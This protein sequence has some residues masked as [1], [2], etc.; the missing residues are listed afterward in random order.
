MTAFLILALLPALHRAGLRFSIDWADFLK[1]YWVGQAMRSAAA[2]AVLYV[3]GFPLRE[4]LIPLWNR[5]WRHKGRFLVV[6]VFIVYILWLFGWWIGLVLIVDTIAFL[7]LFD[8]IA[9]DP[10]KLG[11]IA[12]KIALPAA[13]LF[14]GLVLVFCYNDVVA[15]LEFAE[16]YSP[17]LNQVDRFLLAGWTVSQIAHAVMSRLPQWVYPLLGVIY[18][19]VFS[20]VGATLILVALFS[21]RKRAFQFV[22]AL[23]TAYYVSLLVFFFLPAANPYMLCPG[24]FERLSSS[25]N[26]YSIQRMTALKARLLWAHKVHFPIGTDYFIAFPCMH[27]AMPVISLWFLRQWKRLLVF[28]SLFDTLVVAAI[29]LQEQHFFVDLIGGVMVGALAI[30]MVSQSS[31]RF[32]PNHESV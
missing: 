5:Y 15:S 29:L 27:I 12:T 26:L 8:R 21:T 30:A 16:K 1:L 7:E 23:L 11:K 10:A 6:A 20:Q 22:A 3:I 2:A 32:M 14:V 9:G 25:L 13:Y 28:V 24:H 31:S 19:R 4:T 17:L 18:F